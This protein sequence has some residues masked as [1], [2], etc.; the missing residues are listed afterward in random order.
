VNTERGPTGPDS[1]AT[2]PVRVV[3]VVLNWNGCD[4]TLA[5]LTSLKLA[6]RARDRIVVVDNGS[7]DGSVARI[8]A[9]HPDVSLIEAGTNLGYAGGN[10][11]GIAHAL[12]LSAEYVLILNNDTTCAPELI[13]RLVDAAARHPRAGMLCPRIFYMHEPA[14]VWFDG[15]RWATRALNFRFPGKNSLEAELTDAEHETDYACG[16]ALFVRAEVIRAVGVFNSR[17]FLVWE[18]ADWCYRA[19]EE[20]WRSLVVPAAKIWHRIGVSFGSEASPLR[21]Y[22]SRR[23]R[24]VWLF[25][26]GSFRERLRVSFEAAVEAVP[27]WEIGCDAGGPWVRRL[28]WAARDWVASALGR[29]ERLQYLAKRQAFLDFVRGRLGPPPPLVLDLNRR[30]G[31]RQ[32]SVRSAAAG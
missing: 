17:Y 2:G 30:W 24:L 13:D 1:S 12:A 3:T 25:R 18:E 16:A 27:R 11:L 7:S 6:T 21:T 10:N 31:Q 23:N 29:G 22:F 14:R 9:E 26:H 32:G 20:G 19:R 8:R 4:D 5:C 15:A 28:A